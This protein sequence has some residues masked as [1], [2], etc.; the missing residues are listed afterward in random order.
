MSPTGFEIHAT[1]V[2]NWQNI[3]GVQMPT[4]KIALFYL[5]LT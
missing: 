1:W 2:Q 3:S 4:D 5:F